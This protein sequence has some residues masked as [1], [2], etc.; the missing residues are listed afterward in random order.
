MDEEYTYRGKWDIIT[1]KYIIELD[2]Q[3]HFNDYRLITLNSPLYNEIKSFP[4]EIY[5][6]YCARYK[7]NCLKA[8]S[9]GGKWSN[10]SCEKMFG[11]AQRKGLLNGNGS[12]RFILI[13]HNI[14]IIIMFKGYG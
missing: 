10:V 13:L 2:E 1:E 6:D 8:G 4:L 3:L 7:E 12:P 14:K 5:K 9:H 11:L